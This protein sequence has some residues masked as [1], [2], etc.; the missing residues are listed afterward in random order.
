MIFK[1]SNILGGP[2][3]DQAEQPVQLSVS[4]LERA[5]QLKIRY[6]LEVLASSLWIQYIHS[7]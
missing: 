6:L 2:D 1:L 5:S 7:L 3:P 4:L